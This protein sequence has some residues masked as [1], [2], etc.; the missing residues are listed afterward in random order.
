MFLT[1]QKYDFYI[2]NS[3]HF[4]EENKIKL[5]NFEKNMKDVQYNLL[6]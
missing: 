3:S 6:I 2:M 1:E 5:K 4:S